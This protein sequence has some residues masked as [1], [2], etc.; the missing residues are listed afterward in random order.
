V[1]TT[2]TRPPKRGDTTLRNVRIDDELWAAGGE[3]CERAK[4]RG[5][6]TD[7]SKIARDAIQREI[8]REQDPT[9][10]ALSTLAAERGT[11]TEELEKLAVTQYLAGIQRK[12]ANRRSP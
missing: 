7:R 10:V 6:K 4:A 1:T 8:D 11:T 12:R 9:W 2:T 5:V 3:F